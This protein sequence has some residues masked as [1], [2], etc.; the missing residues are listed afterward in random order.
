M[1]TIRLCLFNSC[2]GQTSLVNYA[3]GNYAGDKD[4]DSTSEIQI[5]N[6]TLTAEARMIFVALGLFELS[7]MWDIVREL[8]G[9]YDTGRS[10]STLVNHYQV[11][12]RNL[13]DSPSRPGNRHLGIKFHWIR[14]EIR[15]GSASI[16]YETTNLI[17]AGG[18]TKVLDR[19]K[20]LHF[21]KIIYLEY[22]TREDQIWNYWDRQWFEQ[23][24]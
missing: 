21:C 10:D 15:H 18:L 12:L 6:A 14:Q 11:C 22:Q 17:S 19:V 9:R 3:D 1:R 23:D 20:H 13:D 5:S 16:K 8:F 2:T 7:W 4:S 24:Y